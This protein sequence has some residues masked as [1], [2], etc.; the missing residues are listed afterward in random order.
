MKYMGSKAR[1]AKDI[2]PIILKDRKHDQWYV[3][4]FAGGANVIQY[5]SGNRIVPDSNR[6][7]IECLKLIRDNPD[8]LPKE[9]TEQMY[10]SIKNSEIDV[11]DGLKGY[12]AFALSYGGKQWGG[13]CRD[14]EGKRNYVQEALNN[15]LKQS[16][17]LDKCLFECREY[18]K[19]ELQP[20]SI[21]YCDPP[22]AGTTKYKEAFDH[23]KFWNWVREQAKNGH[24]VFVSE[25]N[26][27]N[28]FKCVW[29]KEIV[30]S[31]TKN[32]G[33]KKGTE[34]LFVYE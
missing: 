31:L 7:L 1:I 25:Y 11:S 6:I 24:Q 12:Y 9:T 10:K 34:R 30:S 18:D 13:W 16:K 20:N 15:A 23:V 32:T 8:Q 14:S 5:V 17:L 28:D 4:P 26:A 2:L 3:E 33:S 27:P 29:E 21:V 22:Y 19:I